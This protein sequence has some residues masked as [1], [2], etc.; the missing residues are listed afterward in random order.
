MAHWK[1]NNKSLCGRD[2]VDAG[3]DGKQGVYFAW[4]YAKIIKANS[5]SWSIGYFNA[6]IVTVTK[7]Q[8]VKSDIV[9]HLHTY[10]PLQ[11]VFRYTELCCDA[12]GYI[13]HYMGVASG[14][15]LQG[16]LVTYR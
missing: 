8:I 10:Q 13:L 12:G 11:P 9:D 15:T 6:V 7:H 2:L 16:L 3:G 1:G 4:P 14:N 5:L